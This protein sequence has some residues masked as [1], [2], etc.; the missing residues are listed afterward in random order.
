M[1]YLR[2]QTVPSGAVIVRRG[3]PA[4]SMF[5]VADGEVEVE[6]EH[7][8]STCCLADGGFFGEVGAAQALDAPRPRCGRTQATK[9]LVLDSVDLQA[10][11]E[12]SPEVG[13]RIGAV[14]V[15]RSEFNAGGDILPAEIDA[16]RPRE[17]I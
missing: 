2:A 11:M 3:E 13:R 12:R 7:D 1:R 6:I 4:E 8:P 5:F 10:L 9:L 17:N 15:E 16:R 14:V